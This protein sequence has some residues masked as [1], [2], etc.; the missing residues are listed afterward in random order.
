MSQSLTRPDRAPIDPRTVGQ[1]V[2]VYLS[3]YSPE[4]Y[5]ESE[6]TDHEADAEFEAVLIY[7][8][9]IAPSEVVESFVCSHVGRFVTVQ[10]AGGP[11]LY[12]YANGV[13]HE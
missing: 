4:S 11:V 1:A 13:V 5:G 9:V 10:L 2:S 12:V 7:H 3:H 6:T 8:A